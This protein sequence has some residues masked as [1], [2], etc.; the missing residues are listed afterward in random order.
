MKLH[1]IYLTVDARNE[2]AIKLYEKS[3]FKREG[4]F[5]DDLFCDRESG[6]IDRERYAVI[7]KRG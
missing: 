2:I 6:F 3:G 1:K 5:V 4:Y 7:Q